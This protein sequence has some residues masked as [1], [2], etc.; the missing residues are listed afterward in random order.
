[1]KS[2]QPSVPTHTPP[3]V[4]NTVSKAPPVEQIPGTKWYI[5]PDGT[6]CTIIYNSKVCIKP[7][8]IDSTEC[9]AA[10]ISLKRCH[11][12]IDPSDPNNPAKWKWVD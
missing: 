6:F 10:L 5:T 9:K 8:Q 11:L 1:L 7:D 4:T 3:V 2:T 12:Q